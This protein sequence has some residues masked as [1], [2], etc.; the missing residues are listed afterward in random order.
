M[1]ENI[2]KIFLSKQKLFVFGDS[3][4]RVFFYINDNILKKP[5]FNVLSIGGATA[6]GLANP[7]SK[8]NALNLFEEKIRSDCKRKDKLYFFLGE[9]DCGFVIWYRSKKYDESIEF[10]FNRSIN[11]YKEFLLKLKK[12]GFTDI[13]IIETVMP[14]IF[15][16]FEG[17]IAHERKEVN[18]SIQERTK[19]TIQ[20]NSKLEEIAKKY[21]FGFVKISQDIIDTE[22]GLIKK[23]LLN[24]DKTNHHLSNLKFAPIM[25]KNIMKKLN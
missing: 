2:K 1:F 4:A 24:E 10:Q 9:V 6:Q 18:I 25:Y 8:T 22:T 23:T 13:N 11:N 7:R 20:Y 16:G 17:Q 3:H 5:K 14:T 19:L 12:S 15:D 21:D